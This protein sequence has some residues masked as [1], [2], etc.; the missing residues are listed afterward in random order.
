VRSASATLPIAVP[1]RWRE[2]PKPVEAYDPATWIRW[3]MPEE[4]DHTIAML[5]MHLDRRVRAA[6]EAERARRKTLAV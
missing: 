5:C 6:A 2:G 4:P 1:A 3:R